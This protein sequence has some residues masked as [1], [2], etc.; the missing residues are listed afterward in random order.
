MDKLIPYDRLKIITPFLMVIT[1]LSA[2]KDNKPTC[3][4][5]ILNYFLY[6][7]T[8]I[9]LFLTMGDLTEDYLFSDGRYSLIISL[10]GSIG[11]IIALVYTNNVW[12]RHLL[13]IGLITCLAIGSKELYQRYDKKEIT[14]VIKKILVIIVICAFI[15]LKFPEY[16]KPGYIRQLVI[17]LI[18][19]VIL[20][21]VDFFIFK[22][23]Y[24]KL[25][26]TL[27]VFVFTMFIIYDTHRVL[28]DSKECGKTKN[29]A[30]Y[31]DNVINM[32]LNLINLFN[33]LLILEN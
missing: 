32:F 13:W 9:V 10:L 20:G 15:A 4:R 1:Y 2:F 16:I 21:L 30:E 33:N 11:I 31:L 3:D 29:G 14:N 6:L 7:V 18:I 12:I 26:S 24:H 8:S 22:Q 17:S 28:I 23:K 19:V 25:I 27:I 5:Y